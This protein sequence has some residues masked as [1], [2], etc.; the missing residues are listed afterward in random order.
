VE[1]FLQGKRILITRPARQTHSWRAQL[2]AAGAL[3]KSIPMLE[4]QPIESGPAAQQIKNH[5]LDFDQYQHAIF[6]SQNA[7]QLGCDWLENYWPQL[8]LGARYYGI[9]AAT[10]RALTDRGVLAEIGGHSMDSETLLALPAL[11][12]L[13][14][15]R[16][17]IFRGQG[18]RTLIGDTLRQRGARV[19]YCELYRR[20]LPS[21]ARAQLAHCAQQPDA[22]TV[23]SG[24]TLAN[25]A[26]CIANSARI[27]LKQA[28]LVC[29]S[30]R[31]ATEARELGFTLVHTA[32]NAGD[33]AMLAALKEALAAA[34][35][36]ASSPG[37]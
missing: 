22:I 9:G 3:V 10:G 34:D 17:L 19:D 12:S 5:I 1:K 11:R 30:R 21:R 27:D 28:A 18:G 15:E 24:E 36:Q 6:V 37:E 29:P 8:P 13:K 16:V 4:I 20:C 26:A 14:D 25:L 33:R 7:V 35:R 31:V 23:H 32:E 2:I